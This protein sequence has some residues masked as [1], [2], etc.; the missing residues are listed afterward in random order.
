MEL[1]VI[2]HIYEAWLQQFQHECE[3]F[4]STTSSSLE[5][6]YV[7]TLLKMILDITAQDIR[8]YR[9]WVSGNTAII[10]YI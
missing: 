4:S 9:N 2:F 6:D 8:L 10:H 1:D 7:M 3:S 5:K